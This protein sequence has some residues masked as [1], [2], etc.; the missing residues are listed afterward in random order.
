MFSGLLGGTLTALGLDR[1]TNL[2][3]SEKELIK[4]LGKEPMYKFSINK[5]DEWSESLNLIKK[6]YLDK[7]NLLG[8]IPIEKTLAPRLE[9]ICGADL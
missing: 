3:F 1:K 8:L 5:K 6:S 7:S 4:T 2:V 9:S